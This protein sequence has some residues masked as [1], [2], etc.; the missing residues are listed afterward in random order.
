MTLE[1]RLDVV[2]R[3]VSFVVDKTVDGLW[4]YA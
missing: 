3:R 1:P 2:N 4:A